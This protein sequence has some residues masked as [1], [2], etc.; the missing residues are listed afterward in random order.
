[1]T[2]TRPQD[3]NPPEEIAPEVFGGQSRRTFLRTAALAGAGALVA[4]ALPGAAAA[5]APAARPA[6]G[7]PDVLAPTATGNGSPRGV[8]MIDTVLGRIRADGVGKVLAHEHLYVDFSLFNGLDDPHYMKPVGG[9]DK[10]IDVISKYVLA[11]KAQGVELI[12]DWGCMGVG[13]SADTARKVAQRTGVNVAIPTGIY[14]YLIEPK[15]DGWTVD[16]LT[17]FM[18][19]EFKHGIDGTGIRPAFVKLGANPVPTKIETNIHRAATQAAA[20]VGATVACHLPFPLDA[21]TETEIARARQVWA[22]ARSNGVKPDRFVWGHANGAIKADKV[23]PAHLDSARAQYFEL[24]AEGITLQFDAVGS[25]P[26]NGAD[27]WFGGPTDPA[28]FLDLLESFV[29]HGYGDRVML[30]NDCSVYV[31]PGGG[32]G[33]ELA[34]DYAAAGLPNWQ[35]P[36][37]IR[38]L[39]GTFEAPLVARI[40]SAAAMQI[41]STT[42]ARVFSRVRSS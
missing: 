38:Y 35:Y 19:G 3:E 13:R 31:N 37:D 18:V 1:M 2:P 10:A 29:D 14:K 6:P 26:A 9:F 20:E 30:S 25:D 22:I 24:A 39:Y 16:Q 11:V 34:A 23:T 28:V 17:A 12:V 5:A 32:I 33:G 42:P 15:F 36:R 8:R 40:G 21:R 7:G 41:L 4:G 27:P